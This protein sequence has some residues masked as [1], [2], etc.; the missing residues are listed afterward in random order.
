MPKVGSIRQPRS[1]GWEP[2][3][4]VIAIL[5]G[6]YLSSPFITPAQ[7]PSLLNY[8][9]RVAV[10]GT[11][12]EGTGLF[13]LAL[14]NADGSITYWSNSEDSNGDGQPDDALSVAVNRGLYSVALGD[15][16]LAHMA[17]LPATVFSN[18]SV[19]LRVWFND[20]VAGF[21]HLLPDQ[22]IAA[23][24]YALMAANVAD[25]AI[26]RAKLDPDLSAE[27]NSFTTVSAE[28]QDAALTARGYQ[29]F[30]TVPAPAWVNGASTDAPSARSGHSAVW[31][32]AAFV[33]WGGDIG[34]S[35]PAAGGAAYQPLSDHWRIL[36]PLNAPS[37][38]SAHTAVWSGTEMIIW[39][40]MGAGGYLNS[41]ARWNGASQDWTA[42]PISGAP[43][44]RQGH[45]AVWTGSQMIVWGGLNA[46]GLLD[47]GA[48]FDPGSGQWSQLAS[49]APPS[50][51]SG[52]T[53]VWTGTRLIVWGGQGESGALNTG[54]QLIFNSGV[55]GSAWQS[56]PSLGAPSPRE[57]HTAM[58]TGSKMILWGGRNGGVYADDGAA[59]D[60]E[61]N[62]WSALATENAPSPRSDHDA[63]WTG[64]EMIVVGG[65]NASGA[66]ASGAAYNPATNKWRPL[67][68]PGAVAA[69]SA[70][71]AIWSG[72][73]V[74]IF[75][76][77]ANGQR[78]AALQKVNPQPAW[79]FYRKL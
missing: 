21:Q 34:Q 77:E 12:F 37:A 28:P 19:F 6:L 65:A 54:A 20:G 64:S 14:V 53:A 43:E 18:S 75:G 57:G 79:H 52:A 71:T 50:A 42:L 33:I 55:A 16:T 67:T 49:S 70:A 11:V 58:W 8:Q 76:G 25:G 13:K 32:G 29:A 69:R 47:D 23:V 45:I 30:M 10:H 4:P 51:R 7:V 59:Y 35:L 2:Q 3:A 36:S 22:L 41:G 24:G 62:T 72:T 31:T 15:T 48:S 68:N 63:V 17:P 39:G 74:L 40:G 66:L 46:T 5:A 44:G 61:T 60:P 1:F 26:S 56:L 78:L 27:V 9:G 73:E 38:R